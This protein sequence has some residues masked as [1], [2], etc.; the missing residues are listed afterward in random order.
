MIFSAPPVSIPHLKKSGH[1]LNYYIP[2]KVAVELKS[3]RTRHTAHNRNR[4]MWKRQTYSQAAINKWKQEADF[5]NEEE[6]HQ[7]PKK[8]VKR[9]SIFD[10]VTY[11]SRS[12]RDLSM[13]SGINFLDAAAVF[14][15]ESSGEENVFEVF[16]KLVLKHDDK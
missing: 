8:R 10:D 7:L 4:N 13:D 3:R 14:S 9:E 6:I 16:L 12:A 5:N 15:G 11:H 1:S 2:P